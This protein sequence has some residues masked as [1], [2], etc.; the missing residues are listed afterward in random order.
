VEYLTRVGMDR[1]EE[2]DRRLTRMIHEGLNEMPGVEV[3]GPEDP[4]D[5]LGIVSFNVG[6][7]NPHEVALALDAMANIMVRSGHHCA[8]P[9]MRHLI[10]APQGTVRASTYLYN[11]TEEAQKLLETVEQITKSL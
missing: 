3:Y 9:L 1:V 4:R 7:L 10:N 11:T 6:D 5:R 8:Q 2:H